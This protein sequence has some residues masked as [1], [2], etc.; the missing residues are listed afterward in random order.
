[1]ALFLNNSQGATKISAPVRVVSVYDN[2]SGCPNTSRTNPLLTAT[3]NVS[4]PSY[5]RFM[6]GMIR[7]ASGRTD[8]YMNIQG[9]AGSNYS[10]NFVTSRL[11]YTSVGTWDHVVFDNGYY[12]NSS[13]NW[14]FSI[15]AQSPG[16]WGCTRVFGQFFILVFEV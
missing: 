2:D 3:I 10:T 16:S 1:M 7:N 5:F 4:N 11:N 9:P 13:G 8:A 6:G 12:G 14:T 15:T